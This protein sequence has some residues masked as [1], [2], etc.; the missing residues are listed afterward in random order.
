MIDNYLRTSLIFY[1]LAEKQDFRK[2]VLENIRIP[3][4]QMVERYRLPPF[5]ITSTIPIGVPTVFKLYCKYTDVETADLLGGTYGGADL[6]SLEFDGTNYWLVYD[7]ETYLGEPMPTGEQY[8]RISDGFRTWESEIINICNC[9]GNAIDWHGKNAIEMIYNTYKRGSSTNIVRLDRHISP[10]I[11]YYNEKSYCCW[12]QR[13]GVGYSVESMVYAIY[14]KECFISESYGIGSGTTNATDNEASPALIIADDGHIVMAHERLR[15]TADPDHW[16]EMQIKRSDNPED[17]TSWVNAIAHNA[18]YFI[19]LGVRAGTTR[20]YSWPSF[21]KLLNSKLFLFMTNSYNADPPLWHNIITI[22]RSADHGITWNDMGGGAAPYDGGYAL[23]G[24]A[25]LQDDIFYSGVCKHLYNNVLHI[26]VWWYDDS[27]GN[28]PDLYYIKSS[29]NGVTWESISGDYI[30]DIVAGGPMAKALMDIGD[31]LVKHVTVPENIIPCSGVI[32]DTGIPY[33]IAMT[34]TILTFGL[35]VYYWNG[36]AWIETDTGLNGFYTTAHIFQRGDVMELIVAI[37]DNGTFRRCVYRSRT[38]TSM[39]DWILIKEITEDENNEYTISR[40]ATTFNYTNADYESFVAMTNRNDGLYSDFYVHAE[41]GICGC[42]SGL[43]K[44]ITIEYEN[45]HDFAGI[46]SY[47]GR[48]HLCADI[49]KPDHKIIKSGKEREGEIWIQK[50]ITQKIYRFN[51]LCTESLIDTLTMI[52]S[53]ETITVY[54][55][56]ES[57]EVKEFSVAPPEWKYEGLGQLEISFIVETII[58]TNCDEDYELQEELILNGDFSAWTGAYP[59]RNPDDWTIFED[60]PAEISEVA[61][62]ESHAN[63]AAAGIGACNIYSEGTNSYLYPTIPILIIGKIYLIEIEV[64]KI[65]NGYI[66]FRCGNTDPWTILSTEGIHE[67]I[68][69]AAGS[70]RFLIHR[71]LT[72]DVTI[73]NVSVK[74]YS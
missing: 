4:A 45:T 5:N 31:T 16:S 51:I 46:L 30:Q 43:A 1:D 63:A 27:V 15:G 61:P 57:A 6:L 12:M 8:V 54:F 20:F 65:V 10:Q 24:G 48:V 23:C 17:E 2:K 28:Y 52:P 59:N 44:A 9:P 18:N 68:K 50:I 56:N 34:G 74:L 64:T 22:H 66:Y 58:K 35:F 7:G 62:N 21:D 67:F 40:I 33:I 47:K 25:A 11:Y 42:C 55:D 39:N 71:A 41:I 72:C 70:T 38:L 14:H 53:Y 49:R 26:F 3:K 29:D 37:K 69:K 73:D 60:D 32:T 13:G 19:E 36:V